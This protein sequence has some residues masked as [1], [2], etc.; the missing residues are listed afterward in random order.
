V[1]PVVGSLVV[2]AEVGDSLVGQDVEEGSLVAG[3][4]GSLAAVAGTL[5]MLV[6]LEEAQ[7]EEAQLEALLDTG[8]VL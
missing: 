6:V 7:L 4:E 5:L 2:W 8:V 3:A 1:V